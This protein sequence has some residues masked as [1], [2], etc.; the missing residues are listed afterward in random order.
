M[1]CFYL[2][3]T[4]SYIAILAWCASRWSRGRFDILQRSGFQPC[5][6]LIPLRNEAVNTESLFA[7]F[8]KIDHPGLE[9]LLIDD[10][11]EDATWSLIQ[12]KA[13]TDA[14]V[15]VLRSPG[16][17]KKAAIEFGVKQATSELIL[18]SDADCRFPADWVSTMTGPF[19]DPEVQLVCGPVSSAEGASFFDRFQQIEWASILLVTQLFFSIKRPMICS[20]ANM[21]YRK[22]AFQAVGGYEQDR[23]LLSGDDE[24]LLKRIAAKFGSESCLYLSHVGEPVLTKAQKAFSDLLNQRIRW[25]EKWKLHQDWRHAHA[26]LGT[27][28]AQ[29]IW[30][31][32]VVLLGLG[33]YGALAFILVW[34]GKI[35]AESRTLGRV[36]STLGKDISLKDQVATGVLHPF[37]VILVAAG[38]LRGKF[39]WKGRAN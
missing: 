6:L 13:Q 3:W 9:I 27:F 23:H 29:L 14:R 32:S 17:G 26:A 36:L 33:A 21:A 24:F 4:L 16:V 31:G 22:S 11:S 18:C 28:T 7:E 19:I 15:K 5:S 12:V 37:Y 1:I 10:Q 39:H 38:T 25:A 35:W 2:F 8:A 30:L 34:V 20:A